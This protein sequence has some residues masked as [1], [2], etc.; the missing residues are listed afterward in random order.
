M[1]NQ[2]IHTENKNFNFCENMGC[3]NTTPPTRD[4]VPRSRTIQGR[5]EGERRESTIF[6]T[7]NKGLC[8]MSNVEAPSRYFP[9]GDDI[10]GR[11]KSSVSRGRTI[12]KAGSKDSAFQ[13]KS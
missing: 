3:Y 9:Q 2:P 5:G 4:L 10:V 8:S 13:R 7:T 12:A 6:N 1:G 11:T